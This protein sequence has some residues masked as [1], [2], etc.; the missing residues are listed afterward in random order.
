MPGARQ[1]TTEERR[2]ACSVILNRHPDSKY[3][4]HS[5]SL[6]KT[7]LPPGS[8][9]ALKPRGVILDSA[10]SPE[11]PHPTH[12]QIAWLSS[13]ARHFPRSPRKASEFCWCHHLIPVVQSAAVTRLQK[14]LTYS[15]APTPP[16]TCICCTATQHF[17]S[18]PFSGHTCKM[19]H[20]LLGNWRP[21]RRPTSL[22]FAYSA[23]A[24]VSS[25]GPSYLLLPPPEMHS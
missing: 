18:K 9:T 25:S 21:V 1:E 5:L 7:C 13:T 15:P 11:I 12:Q 22:R 19:T 16:L 17:C 24:A 2:P 8:P 20:K 4:A 3:P 6:P 23:L 14:P 10:L